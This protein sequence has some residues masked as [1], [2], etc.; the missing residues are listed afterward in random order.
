EPRMRFLRSSLK[1]SKAIFTRRCF[2]RFVPVLLSGSLELL[3]LIRPSLWA[4]RAH[5]RR[6]DEASE[7]AL[8]KEK[9]PSAFRSGL[10]RTTYT[11]SSPKTICGHWI[12]LRDSS[13]SWTRLR[14]A[15]AVMI[16][17]TNLRQCIVGA[18][19]KSKTPTRMKTKT[20]MRMKTTTPTWTVT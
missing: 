10:T 2:S 11:T 20:P 12:C 6:S 13:D 17:S 5:F 9:H 14:G 3:L 7:F 4:L 15:K 18:G 16:K 1:R 8:P 19:L